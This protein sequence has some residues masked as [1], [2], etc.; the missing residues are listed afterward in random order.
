MLSSLPSGLPGARAQVVPEVLRKITSAPRR[1]NPRSAGLDCRMV[2]DLALDV[3]RDQPG[4]PAPYDLPALAK[5]ANEDTAFHDGVPRHSRPWNGR[6]QQMAL[7]S[8]RDYDM[9]LTSAGMCA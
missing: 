5:L 8:P 1:G 4:G 6:W 9:S 2:G 3:L 7:D